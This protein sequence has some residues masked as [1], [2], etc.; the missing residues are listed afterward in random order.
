MRSTNS[1]RN[2]TTERAL[3]ID[4]WAWDTILPN[5]AVFVGLDLVLGALAVYM[6]GRASSSDVE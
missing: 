1:S 5:L 6:L 3:V 2:A 4:G